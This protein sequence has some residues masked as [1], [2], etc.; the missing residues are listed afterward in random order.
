MRVLHEDN[1]LLALYRDPG[2]LV[3]GDRTGDVSLLELAK[4]YLKK[5]YDKPGEVFL[6]LVHRLDR[7]VSGV[8]MFAR[9]S[10]A[11]SR[12]ST[13]FRSRDVRKVYLAVV[14]G[15][16]EDTEGVIESYLQRKETRSQTVT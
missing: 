3:Q 6:G 5:A 4:A 13:Q 9:T 16:L 7:P 2:V 1:H 11:A 10:K 15:R 8:V 14:A 12:L